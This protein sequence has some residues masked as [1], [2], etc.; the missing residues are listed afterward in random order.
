MLIIKRPTIESMGELLFLIIFLIIWLLIT[1]ATTSH[2]IQNYKQGSEVNYEGWADAFYLITFGVLVY[3]LLEFVSAKIG[4][5][6]NIIK[7]LLNNSNY[8][9][10]NF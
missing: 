10:V 4:I 3:Y 2:F 8:G 6:I 5:D 9:D 7:H 1:I